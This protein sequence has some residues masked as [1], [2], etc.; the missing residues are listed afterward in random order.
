MR[1]RPGDFDSPA[2]IQPQNRTASERSKPAVSG[3]T[4]QVKF[5]EV[6]QVNVKS[7]KY[8]YIPGAGSGLPLAE[9]PMTSLHVL[10]GGGG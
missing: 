10:E 9:L 5:A 8:A 7:R 6:Q 2:P 1:V 3:H 4:N